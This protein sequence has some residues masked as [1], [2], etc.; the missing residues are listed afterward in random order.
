MNNNTWCTKHLTHCFK[1][2]S[3]SS[4]CRRRQVIASNN[5]VEDRDIITSQQILADGQQIESMADFY[6]PNAIIKYTKGCSLVQFLR[7]SFYPVG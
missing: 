5:S 2:G 1:G 3:L 6:V 4:T 7:Y